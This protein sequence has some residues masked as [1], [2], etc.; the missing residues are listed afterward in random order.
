MP[1][2]NQLIR[3]GREKMKPKTAAPA[4]M[5]SPAT[6]GGLYPGVY[7]DPQEAE[8]GPEKSGPGP[9]DQRVRD[10]HLHSRGGA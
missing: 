3:L 6:P 10:Y 9:S 7:L 5:K 4:L 8:L 2:I 1:T